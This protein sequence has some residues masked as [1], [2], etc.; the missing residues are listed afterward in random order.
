MSDTIKVQVRIERD[1]KHGVLND[2]LYFDPSEFFDAAGNRLLTD[3]QIDALAQQRVTSYEKSIDDA[4]LVPPAP[5]PTDD[6]RFASLLGG[7]DDD[8]VKRLWKWVKKHN[9]GGD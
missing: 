7:M 6:E 2:A 9:R 3:A 5:P 8:D 1:T 4:R